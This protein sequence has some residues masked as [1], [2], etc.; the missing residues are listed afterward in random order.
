M[1]VWRDERLRKV[2]GCCMRMSLYAHPHVRRSGSYFGYAYAYN[3]IQQS[4]SN[5]IHNGKK[6][7]VELNSPKSN[8]QMFFGS[9]PGYFYSHQYKIQMTQWESTRAP[10]SWRQHAEGY[11]EFWTAN[12]FGRQA[13]INVGVP[14]EKVF[15]YEHG[16]DSSIWTPVLR[17]QQ[18]K[19]RFLHVDS[20][21]P[22]KRADIAISAFKKA[23][24]DNPDY[25]LILKYSH[26]ENKG[27]DWNKKEVLENAGEWEGNIRHIRENIDL[28]H[29]VSLHHF[30]DVLV[31]PS[32]GE[33]FGF[34]PMQ[35][36]ATGMPVISTS[37]WCSYEKYLGGN[38]IDSTL[39]ISPV[40]ETYQRDGDVVLPDED[41]LIIIM[42]AVAENIQ[43]QSEYFYNQVPQIVEEYSWQRQTDKAL[44]SLINRIGIESF[45]TYKGYLR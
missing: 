17:S 36:I 32:E 22:R 29:L 33:G 42:K 7:N 20:G 9:P 25:E 1:H 18:N 28:R 24:G 40:V 11:D 26:Y 6:L 5:F 10:E 39:G 3:M 44:N 35:A 19:L 13:I 16:V 14:E 30:A 38:I 12:E 45:V 27:L 4:F 15:V 41:S 21:S 34:I 2:Y 43:E 37:R 31:Y 23:F 8:V